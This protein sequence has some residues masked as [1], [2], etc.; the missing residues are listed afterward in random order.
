MVALQTACLEILLGKIPI[1]S[2]PTKPG[3][4]GPAEECSIGFRCQAT[5]Q[6]ATPKTDAPLHNPRYQTDTFAGTRC[7]WAASWVFALTC[8]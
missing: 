1:A 4:L 7:V 2:E 5:C 3:A 6:T 8:Q